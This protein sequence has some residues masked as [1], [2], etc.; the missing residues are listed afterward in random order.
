MQV[1]T[2]LYQSFKGSI[3]EHFKDESQAERSI[4]MELE[5]A[6]KMLARNIEYRDY[7]SINLKNPL[8]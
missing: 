3:Y 7:E 1:K 8:N 6:I 2:R 4:K 5:T